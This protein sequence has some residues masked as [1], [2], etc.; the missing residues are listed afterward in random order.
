MIPGINILVSDA[1]K[2]SESQQWLLNPTVIVE[3][4]IGPWKTAKLAVTA[5]CGAECPE[6]PCIS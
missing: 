4:G 5:F 3:G 1:G 6:K 2:A